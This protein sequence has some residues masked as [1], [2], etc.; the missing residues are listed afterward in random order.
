M[1]HSLLVVPLSALL[2]GGGGPSPMNAAPATGTS[3]PD[4]CAATPY[5][6][7]GQAWRTGFSTGGLIPDR[8]HLPSS[9]PAVVPTLANVFGLGRLELPPSGKVTVI[10]VDFFKTVDIRSA[11]DAP[12]DQASPGDRQ[13]SLGFNHGALVLHHLTAM[14]QSDG[15]GK[16]TVLDDNSL[17]LTRGGRTVTVIPLDFSRYPM[18]DSRPIS[19]ELEQHLSKITDPLVLINMS[20]V[21]IR[22]DA[23]RAIEARHH[24]GA[25]PEGKTSVRPVRYT[26]SSYLNDNAG[27]SAFA[28]RALAEKI[29][30]FSPSKSGV[31]PTSD[32]LKTIASATATLNHGSG[33]ERRRL[34]SIAASGNYG[35]P[36]DGVDALWPGAEQSVISVG[37]TTWKGSGKPFGTAAWANRGDTHAVGEW[38]T[39]NTGDLTALCTTAPTLCVASPDRLRQDWPRLA[40]RGTSFSAPSVTAL[41]ASRLTLETPS[42]CLPDAAKMGNVDLDP[43]CFGA[44]PTP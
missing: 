16:P 2:L 32:L 34:V 20:F 21:M 25:A 14:L 18:T 11:V 41:L 42:G 24:E 12:K 31:L 39:Q 15:F 22:C 23:L 1:N 9:T 6:V 29:F 28:R 43:T 5:Q 44:A 30:S 13:V 35:D 38:Y 33:G 3:N 17:K 7:M 10:I 37:A 40:Y 26:L 8:N 4:P 19:D 36:L 27:K